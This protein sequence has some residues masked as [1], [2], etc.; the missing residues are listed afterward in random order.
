MQKMT[1]PGSFEVRISGLDAGT[2]Y[3]YRVFVRHPQIVT[4]GD[5]RQTIVLKE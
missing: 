4:R 3:Q 1:A 2:H 5:H